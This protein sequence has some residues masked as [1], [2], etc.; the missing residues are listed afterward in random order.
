MQLQS[1]HWRKQTASETFVSGPLIAV[2][3]AGARPTTHPWDDPRFW[4]RPR[5]L[6]SGRQLFGLCPSLGCPGSPTV[7]IEIVAR[8]FCHVIA[9]T[10]VLSGRCAPS[11]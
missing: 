2:Q 1:G 11:R 8:Q 7:T 3:S 9:L 10:V 5:L 4:L 6:Q